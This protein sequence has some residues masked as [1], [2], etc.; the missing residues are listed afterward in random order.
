MSEERARLLTRL[1]AE[2]GCD[3]RT[4][5]RAL[6]GKPMRGEIGRKAEAVVKAWLMGQKGK[7]ANHG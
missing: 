3:R 6:A 7:E 4:I 1:A 2:A 5:A